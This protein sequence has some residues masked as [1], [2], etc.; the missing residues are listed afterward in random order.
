MRKGLEGIRSRKYFVDTKAKTDLLS[1]LAPVLFLQ[2]DCE[3]ATNRD[4]YVTELMKFIKVDCSGKCLHNKDMPLH[5]IYT[6]TSYIN[7]LYGEDLLVYTGQYKFILAI[8]NSI[9]KDYTTEKLWRSL[10]VGAVPIYYGSPLIRDWLPNNKSAIL[11]E[12]FP[13][14]K[15]LSQHLHYL[16]NND[17]AYEEYLEH[18]TLG[19]I[20]NQKLID[21]ITLRPYQN[22]PRNLMEHF[23]CFVCERLYDEGGKVN[24]VTRKQYDCLPPTSALTL[25]V[26]PNNSWTN[27][28]EE[29]KTKVDRLYEEIANTHHNPHYS[30]VNWW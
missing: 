17:T 25:A 5:E 21:E 14:P 6:S 13:T 12:D 19:I 18:K 7:N 23:E 8:E 2:S 3:T 20:S 27:R 26:N 4:E 29:A 24:I 15:L 22:D 11:L 10:D 28:V 30:Y 1:K 16:L 9:C